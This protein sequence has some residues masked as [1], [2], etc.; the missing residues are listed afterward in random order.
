MVVFKNVLLIVFL[1]PLLC[2]SEGIGSVWCF[3]DSAGIKFNNSIIQP[4]TSSIDCRGSCVSIAD[5]SGGLLFY[6]NTC[7]LPYFNLGYDHD[8]VVWNST[9]EVMINGDSLIGLAWHHELLSI[10]IPGNDSLFYL[11]QIGV[12]TTPGLYYSIIHPYF[13]NKRGL[14]TSK[15]TPLPLPDHDIVDACC[16]IK[17]SNGR[18]W[19][20]IV[21]NWNGHNDYFVYLI[22]PAGIQGP[23]V[24]SIGSAT[25]TDAVNIVA[26][27]A[28]DKLLFIN[29][30]GLIE[31]FDFD[32]CTGL[33][34]NPNTIHQEVFTT[35]VPF[36]G[37]AFS[38]NGE[39]LYIS[40]TNNIFGDSLRLFQ[41]NL[42]ATNIF[43]SK[44]V[45]Y[46]QKVPA[47][48][49]E[50]KL[51]PDGKIYFSCLYEYGWPYADSVRNQYNENL[52]VI[53]NPD[54]LGFGCNFQPFSVNL[55]GKRCY[56]GLPNNPNFELGVGPDPTC[57]SLTNGISHVEN[58]SPKFTFSPNPVTDIITV[59]LSEFPSGKTRI[60]INDNL[61]RAVFSSN[62][63]DISIS[64]NLESFPRG[65]YS[66]N[67]LSEHFSQSLKLIKL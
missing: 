20:Y 27:N 43:G 45:I 56:W 14:V 47:S 31:L 32:R 36:A 52:S 63:N 23:V 35:G 59:R 34:S 67:V 21:H 24:Q 53:E 55:G 13:Q 54:V 10:P 16:A 17:H 48:G 41:F 40:N 42:N 18:D 5:S 44:F 2:Y 11:F 51:G 19:W 49:G 33:I 15:N 46:T 37:S 30:F 25:T 58:Q 57:D 12:T 6:A 64:I 28:G 66:V 26:T 39:V 50:L 7:Y 22:T 8:G 60:Q 61:G 62:F 3:G 4:I 38:Q 29:N 65:F 1:S 9:H